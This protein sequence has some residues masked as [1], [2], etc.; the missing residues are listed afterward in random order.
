MKYFV[1]I[2]LA[3]VLF[4]QANA[5]ANPLTLK[6]TLTAEGG[7]AFTYKLVFTEHHGMITGDATTWKDPLHDTKAT[8]TGSIDRQ[9]RTLTFRETGIV[10]NNNF[11][12]NATLCLISATLAYRQD[13]NGISL[14]GPITSTDVGNAGCSKG[15]IIFS[16]EDVIKA[17]FRNAPPDDS[18]TAVAAPV[19]PSAPIVTAPT[20]KITKGIEKSFEW[21]SDTVIVDVWDGGHIDGDVISLSFNGAT[22]LDKYT[23]SAQ[24]KQLRLPLI[25]GTENSLSILAVSEGSEPETTANITLT[26]GRNQYPVIAYNKAGGTA[27]VKI[28]KKK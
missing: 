17:L 9:R 15:N 16:V 23:L 7:E 24:K 6:G 8:I 21:N 10:Y 3:C 11:E 18:V 13:N 27:L 19:A 4:L 5:Q 14:L 22:V 25:S 2:L 1:V 28:R 26:D 12:S 20:A